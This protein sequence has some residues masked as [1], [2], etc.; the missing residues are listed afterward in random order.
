MNYKKIFFL[1]MLFLNSCAEIVHD[2]EINLEPRK[3]FFIN[4]GFTLIFDDNFYVYK[5]LIRM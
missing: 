1:L 4:K 2:K 5:T 3:N